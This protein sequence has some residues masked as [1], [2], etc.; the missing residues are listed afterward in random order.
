M[1]R[2]R[3]VAP[4]NGFLFV[5]LTLL[6]APGLAAQAEPA[7]KEG[8]NDRLARKSLDEA[9]AEAEVIRVGTALDAA[10]APP[11]AKGDAPEHLIRYRVVRVIKGEL[12]DRF[13]FVRTPTD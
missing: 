8:P 3:I 1:T 10:P 5:A 13:V 7:S 11:K 4:T 9:V 6:A 2:N 12:T